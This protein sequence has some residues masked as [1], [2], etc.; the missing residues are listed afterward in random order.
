MRRGLLEGARKGVQ[1]VP[2]CRSRPSPCR[3]GRR[4]AWRAVGRRCSLGVGLGGS[5]ISVPWLMGSIWKA[6]LATGVD[7]LGY[8]QAA[9]VWRY[10]E[11]RGED[12]FLMR[13]E[14]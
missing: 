9:A 11:A 7:G 14:V 10:W 12:G 6:V 13:R 3:A 4:S 8:P 5:R 2:G 1:V